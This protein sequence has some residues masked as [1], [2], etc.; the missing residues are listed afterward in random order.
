MINANWLDSKSCMDNTYI[1]YH[2]FLKRLLIQYYTEQKA[3]RG[4]LL[5]FRFTSEIENESLKQSNLFAYSSF[6][7]LPTKKL[8]D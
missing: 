6:N 5:W 3:R 1:C 8:N 4:V 2:Y 7:L